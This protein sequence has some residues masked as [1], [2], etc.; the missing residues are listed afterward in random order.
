M[1]AGGS[2][3]RRKPFAILFPLVTVSSDPRQSTLPSTIWEPQSPTIQYKGSV[4]MKI[5]S[6]EDLFVEQIED[7][8][9]AEQR[10]VKA[11]P[12]MAEASTSPELRQAFE[13]HLDE[14]RGHV[15]RL[16]QVFL[17]LRKKPKSQ[18]CDAMKGLIEEGEDMI[19]NTGQSPVRDA[20]LI[21]AANRVEHYE[22]AA[23]GTVRTLAKALG[24]N[25][26]VSL[27]NATLAEEKKAD[28]KLTNLA[29]T[30]VNQ[31]ALRSAPV[32][33]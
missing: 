13:S 16:E 21:A 24:V 3:C 20:G 6:M 9:D 12:K 29:E 15:T 4:I 2:A 19:S 32:S 27:L 14:T 23:Y 18:T 5:E 31:Q 28:E 11:L 26:A 1:L 25:E 7:L 10:L 33:R 8:Y 30:S 17:A 22:I